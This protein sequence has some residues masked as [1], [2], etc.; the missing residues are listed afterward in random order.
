MAEFEASRP[1]IR[2]GLSDVATV[3]GITRQRQALGMALIP[4]EPKAEEKAAFRYGN[5]AGR[6]D[7]LRQPSKVALKSGY[8]NTLVQSHASMQDHACSGCHDQL[9]W[10]E[11]PLV[12]AHQENGTG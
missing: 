2:A 8:P 4:L 9:L 3:L 1:G 5:F 6:N 7:V 11:K 10:Q 12:S